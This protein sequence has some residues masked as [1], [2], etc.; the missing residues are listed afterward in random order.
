MPPLYDVLLKNG[1]LI[2]PKNNIDGPADL[3]VKDGKIAAVGPQLPG[4]AER[5]ADVAN[6]YVTPGLI[7]I[8]LHVYGG[9]NAWLFPDPHNLPHGVTTC[10]DTG[11]AGYKDIADFKETIMDQSITRVLA[12]VNIVGAGMTG[13]PEQDTTDMDPIPCAAAVERYP[14]HIVGVKSA[15]F[16]GPGWESTGGAIEA[17][18]RAGSI[19]MVDFSPKP[20]RTYPELLARYSPGDIHTHCYS[21]RTPMLDDNDR[22]FDFVWQARERGVIFDLGHGNASFRF[23]IAVPAHGPRLPSRYHQHRPTPPQPSAAQCHH[24]HHHVENAGLGDAAARGHLPL[25]PAPRRSHPPARARP[26][27]RR[28]RSRCGSAGRARRPLWLCRCHS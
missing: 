4:S 12:F 1:H 18:R 6:L 16:G 28:R 21:M 23:H 3:A 9:F 7:D 22:I 26:P 13:P 14:E 5:Q 17:A 11:G 27:E 19:V 15:H 25:D 20:T 8:H 24:E 2:D 10:V